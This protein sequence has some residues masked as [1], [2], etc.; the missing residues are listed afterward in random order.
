MV[1]G[2]S[3]VSA[4][5]G[6]DDRSAARQGNGSSGQA[7]G[8]R[9]G[10]SVTLAS[11]LC[12]CRARSGNL[13]RWPVGRAHALRRSRNGMP[14]DDSESR[15]RGIPGPED[16]GLPHCPENAIV[17]LPGVTRQ[18]IPLASAALMRCKVTEW[19]LGSGPR[20]TGSVAVRLR[21][22]CVVA[23]RDP[24]TYSVGLGCAQ[25]FPGSGPGTT[26]RRRLRGRPKPSA[27]S[28]RG[29]A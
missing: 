6:S 15:H 11:A 16:P 10:C 9:A 8:R 23:G 22:H 25:A 2:G 19:V 18:P 14:K 13:F 1:D 20:T 17:S 29:S 12:R 3:C 24:A 7:R 5:R 4:G 27:R 28:R 21:P 26:G